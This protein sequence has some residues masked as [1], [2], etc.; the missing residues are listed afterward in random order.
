MSVRKIAYEKTVSKE[1]IEIVELT[2]GPSP[3]AW[4]REPAGNE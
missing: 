2:H 4:T 1:S 3:V